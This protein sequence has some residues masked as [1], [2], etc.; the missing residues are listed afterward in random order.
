MKKPSQ[1]F[2]FGDQTNAS[3]ADLRQLL[4]VNDN[5]VLKSF[6]ERVTYAV[7]I[8]IANLSTIQREWF[9]RFNT[10]LE[11][12]TARRSGAGHNPALELALLCINQLGGFVKYEIVSTAPKIGEG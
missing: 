5:S 3:D 7:R 9:P 4:H 6:F 12:L 1:I 8:E 10:L 2:I 11:L